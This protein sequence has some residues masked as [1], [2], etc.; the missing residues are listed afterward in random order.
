METS[1]AVERIVDEVWARALG[2]IAKN[3]QARPLRVSLGDEMDLVI[4]QAV[5]SALLEANPAFSKMLYT[6]AYVSAKR[7]AYLMTRQLGMP[8]D[9]FWKFDYW[10]PQRALDTMQKIMGRVFGAVMEK[11]KEGHLEL[12]AVDVERGTFSLRFRDCAECSGFAP[13]APMC[14]FHAGLFAGILGALLDRD[15]DAV[16]LNC[17]ASD[18]VACVFL[19]GKPEDRL[20]KPVMDQRLGMAGPQV[21][22]PKRLTDSLDGRAVRE[23]GNLVDVSYYQLLLS[24]VF[25]SHLDVLEKACFDAGDVVGRAVALII[26][27]R[28]HSDARSAV[29]AFYE[30]LRYAQAEIVDMPGQSVE[31]R[32]QEAPEILG[33]LA[34]ATLIPFLCGELQG[35]LSGMLGRPLRF[36]SSERDGGRLVLRFA[37]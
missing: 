16:E 25:L 31:V 7:N 2:K 19:V 35:V 34:Q 37:P 26:P 18:S 30:G 4:P 22:L 29:S 28:S 23:F 5:T 33:P 21:D 14:F 32:V 1:Q 17:R 13:S 3:G 10:T 20:V 9:F 11:Q 8:P 12:T 36:Q 27:R 6:S 24:S 15:L